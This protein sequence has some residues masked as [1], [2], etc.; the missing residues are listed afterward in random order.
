M[1]RAGVTRFGGTILTLSLV[2]IQA[3][4]VGTFIPSRKT[5]HL[6]LGVPNSK[7]I[8]IFNQIYIL[9]PVAYGQ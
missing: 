6:T 2:L 9:N 1:D 3:K 4:I 7:Q 5:S 8:Y